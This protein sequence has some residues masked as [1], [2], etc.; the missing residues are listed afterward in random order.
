MNLN[1]VV[2]PVIA[3]GA[4]LSGVIDLSE[5]YWGTLTTPDTLDATT[6]IGAYACETPDGTFV[7][8]LD[9]YNAL[10]YIT[11]ALDASKKYN[12]PEIMMKCHYIKLWTCTTS[13]VDVDRTGAKTFTA[14][15][16]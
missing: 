11:V 10:V 7:P 3:N 6:V 9:E 15:F 14:A 5:F 4:A 2:N 12:I 13:G 8:L 16:K 1:N